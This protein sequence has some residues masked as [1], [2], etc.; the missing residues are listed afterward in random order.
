[1]HGQV[2]RSRMHPTYRNLVARHSPR[3]PPTATATSAAVVSV[4]CAVDGR[5]HYIT[6]HA[7]GV[8]QRYGRYRALCGHTVT[9]VAMVCPDG[10]PCLS[11]HDHVLA[12]CRTTRTRHRAPGALH[13][14]VAG[15]RD[16]FASPTAG[17]GQR[18]CRDGHRSD[19]R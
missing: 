6:A 14:L 11:C 8:G 18:D 7:F 12:T 3:R 16:R 10:E 15:L 13:R 9:A 4:T 17:A 5:S 19:T 2:I 1:M